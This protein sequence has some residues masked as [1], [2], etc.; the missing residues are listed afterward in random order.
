MLKSLQRT[1][2]TVKNKGLSSA[3]LKCANKTKS[4]STRMSFAQK[5]TMFVFSTAQRC[6]AFKI[7]INKLSRTLSKTPHQIMMQQ[8]TRFVMN[9][10]LPPTLLKGRNI[11][12]IVRKLICKKRKPTVA[13]S[14]KNVMK[15]ISVQRMRQ[16]NLTLK[17]HTFALSLK[18]LVKL[19]L[20]KSK[21]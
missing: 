3:L 13:L 12:L 1:M 6:T 19:T 21:N 11:V 8:S 18:E 20:K 2:K 10:P 15:Q 16:G 17:F 7:S 14:L 5:C 9:L 4:S